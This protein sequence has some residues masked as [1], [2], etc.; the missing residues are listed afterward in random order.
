MQEMEAHNPSI[1]LYNEWMSPSLPDVM[2][3]LSR[4]FD[5]NLSFWQVPNLIIGIVI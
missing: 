5:G 3:R 2:L 4:E 1:N